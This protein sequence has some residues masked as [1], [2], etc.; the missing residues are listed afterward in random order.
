MSSNI[1]QG[2][3]QQGTPQLRMAQQQQDEQWSVSAQSQAGPPDNY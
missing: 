3:Y 2:T 1:R